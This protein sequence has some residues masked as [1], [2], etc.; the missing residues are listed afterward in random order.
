M[1]QRSQVGRREGGREGRRGECGEGR[2]GAKESS[3]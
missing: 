2:D 1:E 3:I